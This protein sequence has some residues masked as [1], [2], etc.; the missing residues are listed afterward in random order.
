MTGILR[1]VLR[2]TRQSIG[3]RVLSAFV[4]ELYASD[5]ISDVEID[6]NIQMLIG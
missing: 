2:R 4:V 1:Q 5:C 3:A 6:T